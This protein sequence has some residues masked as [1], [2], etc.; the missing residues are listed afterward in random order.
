MEK[1]YYTNQ[2]NIFIMVILIKVKQLVKQQLSSYI[3]IVFIMGMLKKGKLM[4]K[5]V[6]ITLHRIIY[7]KENGKTLSHK[8]EF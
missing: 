2:E 7:L 3:R 1:E 4:E 5:V 8:V 6:T